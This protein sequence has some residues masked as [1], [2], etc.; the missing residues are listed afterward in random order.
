MCEKGMK[1]ELERGEGSRLLLLLLPFPSELLQTDPAGSRLR[2]H[3]VLSPK[4]LYPAGRHKL[5]SK[6]LSLAG[7]WSW[8]IHAVVRRG[9]CRPLQMPVTEPRL[10][11]RVF[12]A[13]FEQRM[14]LCAPLGLENEPN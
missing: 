14:N 3:V 11:A 9:E 8:D 13:L 7:S 4:V 10:S 2:G 5:M 12:R 1:G 6:W